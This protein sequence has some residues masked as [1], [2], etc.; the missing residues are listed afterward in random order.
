MKY[1]VR[2]LKYFAW[3]CVLYVAIVWLMYWSG[4]FAEH[5]WQMM[6][7]VLQSQRGMLMM[8]AFVVLAAAYPMFGFMRK[9]I[10]GSVARD[11]ELIIR[12][13]LAQGFRLTGERDGEMTFRGEGFIKRL[14]LLF[15][16]DITVR[17]TGSGLEIEGI[18]RA[19]AR[20]AYRLDGYIFNSKFDEK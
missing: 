4:S 19:V 3:L 6:K 15:E 13:F 16:D 17:D 12:A 11:R 7:V 14:S 8:A 20:I 2:A 1:F 10:G 9:R 5:P 18:R